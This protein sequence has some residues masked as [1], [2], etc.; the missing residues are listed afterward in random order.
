MLF[1]RLIAALTVGIVTLASLPAYAADTRPY[2]E[3]A[4][5]LIE[6]YAKSDL[7]TGSVLVAKEGKVLLRRSFGLANRE[8]NVPNTPET[9][10]RIGSIT[11][12]FT[13]TAILQ[14]AEAGKLSVDDPISRY[15]PSAP[16]TWQRV[17]IKHL[18]TH[19][20]G[21]PS[22]TS[23][24][25]FFSNMS[26]EDR[27][28]EQI[29]ALTLNL[30]LK[31]EPGSKF[32]YD[33][34]G[35]VLLGH[36]IERASGPG[37]AA[38]L[39]DHIFRPLGMRN[40]GFDDSLAILAN[41]ASGYDLSTAGEWKNAPYIAMSLPYAAGS[42]Y[43]TV[44][45][46]L[47]WDQALA[48][49]KILRPASAETMFTNYGH[50]YGYGWEISTL[51]GRKSQAHQGGINGFQTSIRRFPDE[52]LTIIVLAN[53]TSSPS[54]KI[55][56][57]LAGLYFGTFALPAEQP[58]DPRVLDKYVGRYQLRPGPLVTVSREGSRLFALTQERRIE[59]FAESATRFFAKQLDA[60]V[61][62]EVD[63]EG[64]ATGFIRRQLGFEEAAHRI[65]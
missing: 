42:L 14:L 24:P 31:F 57:E 54:G 44:D 22:Y 9:K 15:Y 47:L 8:W 55:A 21:I 6:F 10:F 43:S 49:Q 50:G 53:T 39:E 52:K 7:F 20:S 36:V 4:V 59:L 12:Q 30:P 17:T 32:E 51:Q 23:L 33:N 34:S 5:A 27:T 2:S 48:A 58:S 38:Y 40:S 45:D 11:K 56:R 16:E 41:R 61:A 29:I 37:Y 18:L 35:Y 63:A 28:P 1:S 26:K 13:A 65:E 3:R 25:T 64:R 46:L 62:F 19:T 60:S